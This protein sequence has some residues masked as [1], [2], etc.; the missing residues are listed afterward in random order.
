MSC[1][2]LFF[3]LSSFIVVSWINGS[4]NSNHS[5]TRSNG[6]IVGSRRLSGSVSRR[7]SLN[8]SSVVGRGHNNAATWSRLCCS[9]DTLILYMIW[10]CIAGGSWGASF[11]MPTYVER[12]IKLDALNAIKA[13]VG[14]PYIVHEMSTTTPYRLVGK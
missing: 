10:I 2:V 12:R 3:F 6:G 14:E 5:A 9:S 8:N 11:W 7:S 4:S 1:F 13:T